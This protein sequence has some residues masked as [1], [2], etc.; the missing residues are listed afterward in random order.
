VVV[1]VLFL[2][3]KVSAIETQDEVDGTVVGLDGFGFVGAMGI[4]IGAE[5]A[6]AMD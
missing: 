5:E 2:Q 4:G 1:E 3:L 6:S